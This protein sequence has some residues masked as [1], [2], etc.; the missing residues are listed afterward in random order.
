MVTDERTAVGEHRAIAPL[1]LFNG[2]PTCLILSQQLGYL[3]KLDCVSALL[4]STGDREAHLVDLTCDVSLDTR[5]VINVSALQLHNFLFVAI[6][7]VLTADD[8]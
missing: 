6:S 2:V 4:V 3:A 1:L 7:E 5:N 8:A